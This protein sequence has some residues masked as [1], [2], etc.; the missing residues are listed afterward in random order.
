MTAIMNKAAKW[1]GNSLVALVV[2]AL[3]FFFLAPHL[4]GMNFFTIY[5]GS[6]M[7]TI[8]VGSVVMVQPVG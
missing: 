2:L 3:A 4:L 5:S 6:M 1:I 7:P 8:T